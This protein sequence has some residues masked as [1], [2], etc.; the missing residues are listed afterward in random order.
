MKLESQMKIESM[1]EAN[2]KL[3]E[4]VESLH[5]RILELEK[6]KSTTVND[7]EFQLLLLRNEIDKVREEYHQR[8]DELRSNLNDRIIV[9]NKE[10]ARFAERVKQ[11]TEEL[12]RKHKDRVV[13]LEKE[14]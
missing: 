7:Y 11:E 8:E 5:E 6:Q 10:I 9:K 2:E 12:M 4:E 3:E 1:M 13:A 14:Y